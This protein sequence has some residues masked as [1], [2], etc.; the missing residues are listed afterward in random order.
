MGLEDNTWE[1]QVAPNSGAAN[2]YISFAVN[3]GVVQDQVNHPNLMTSAPAVLLGT[4]NEDVFN[5]TD[6]PTNT[7]IDGGGG[8][9][10][11]TL[12]LDEML[13]VNSDSVV[14]DTLANTLEV[15]TTKITALEDSHF[16]LTD[17]NGN[18]YVL[19]NVEAIEVADQ[20]F[21][22]KPEVWQPLESLTRYD[23]TV[24]EDT[25]D[26]NLDLLLGSD[27]SGDLELTGTTIMLADEAILTISE[28]TVD[29]V[30]VQ[31]L[32]RD[33]DGAKILEFNGVE[34]VMFTTGD[35]GDTDLLVTNFLDLI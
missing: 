29:G 30:T 22:I 16:S 25:V 15:G 18:L 2:D 31:Q 35:T 34:N 14:V 7:V 10:F 1:I 9:E 17:A 23:G 27:Q 19:R 24:W 33:H 4:A 21:N 26:I 3:A 13:Y 11:D 28:A 12:V 5:L 32:N 6:L 8:T 20:V